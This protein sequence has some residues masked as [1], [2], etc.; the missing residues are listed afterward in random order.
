MITVIIMVT[1]VKHTVRKGKKTYYPNF[2]ESP[3]ET[4]KMAPYIFSTL[5][6]FMQLSL[7]PKLLLLI[8]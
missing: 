3:L 1:R 4:L 8:I 7:Q 2:P 6:Y 5:N